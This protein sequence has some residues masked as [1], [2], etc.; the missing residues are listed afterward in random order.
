MHTNYQGHPKSRTMLN[1]V[2]KF[3]QCEERSTYFQVQTGIQRDIRPY[4][5]IKG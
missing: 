4:G 3:A 2:A 5:E 1:R